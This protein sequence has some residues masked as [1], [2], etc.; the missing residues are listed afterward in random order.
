MH[1][2]GITGG[3]R[4]RRLKKKKMKGEKRVV[5]SIGEMSR[6]GTSLYSRPSG[7]LKGDAKLSFH[8]LEKREKKEPNKV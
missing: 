1:L 5:C 8:A 3:Q 6:A 2:E 4:R 7:P